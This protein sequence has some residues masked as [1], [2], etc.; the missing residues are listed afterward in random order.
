MD[1]MRQQRSRPSRTQS[2][3]LDQLEERS[4]I[5]ERFRRHLGNLATLVHQL[6]SSKPGALA[7]FYVHDQATRQLQLAT[8]LLPPLAD[9]NDVDHA[10]HDSALAHFRQELGKLCPSRS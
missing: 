7:S 6:R 5:Q 8:E 4:R 1:A 10:V 3:P 9:L 2:Q